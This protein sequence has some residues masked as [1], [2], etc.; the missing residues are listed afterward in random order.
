MPHEVGVVLAIEGIGV[1]NHGEDK[2]L[3]VGESPETP[4]LCVDSLVDCQVFVKLRSCHIL[5]AELLLPPDLNGTN[6]LIITLQR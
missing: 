1:V 2:S 4:A 6:N 5:G 3:W